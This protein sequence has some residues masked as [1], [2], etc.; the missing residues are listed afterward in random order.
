MTCPTG[1]SGV[2]ISNITSWHQ[3]ARALPSPI[4]S[5]FP[6]FSFSLSSRPF[7]TTSSFHHSPPHP[8]IPQALAHSPCK[9]SKQSKASAHVVSEDLEIFSL[10]QTPQTHNLYA[11]GLYLYEYT[12]LQAPRNKVFWSDTSHAHRFIRSISRP[13]CEGRTFFLTCMHVK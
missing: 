7:H 4:N 3:T 6:P 12:Y 2:S 1:K 13:S 10:V 11:C 5:L 9:Q 8:Q